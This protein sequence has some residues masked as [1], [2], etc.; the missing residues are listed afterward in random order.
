MFTLLRRK[1]FTADIQKIFKC[2]GKLSSLLAECGGSA[3]QV[4]SLHDALGDCKAL[5]TILIHQKVSLDLI[6]DNSRS[7]ESAQQR[8]TNPLLRAGLITL[9]VAN[10]LAQQMTCQEYL[11]LTDNE[12]ETMLKGTGLPTGSIKACLAKR[13]AYDV[14]QST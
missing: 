2:K 10:K 4:A 6:C 3:E 13:K 11:K 5:A 14:G 7:L 1:V 12:L 8:V 9:V